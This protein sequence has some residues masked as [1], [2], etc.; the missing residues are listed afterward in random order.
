[1]VMSEQFLE[2]DVLCRTVEGLE[3]VN[4]WNNSISMGTTPTLI[5]MV[6]YRDSPTYHNYSHFPRSISEWS[7][8]ELVS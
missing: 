8:C 2:F 1:M 6:R 7:H 5:S 4:D 3:R